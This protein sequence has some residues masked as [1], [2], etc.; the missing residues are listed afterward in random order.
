MS[1]WTVEHYHTLELDDD[2]RRLVRVLTHTLQQLEALMSTQFDALKAQ[3]DRS[4][5]LL[6][7]LS[8]QVATLKA[9][10]EDPAAIQAAADAL[11]AANDAAEG[12]PPAP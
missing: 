10:S 12:P 11:K 8:G 1:W 3:V 7:A 6:Q 9:A 2:T 5:V 4:I